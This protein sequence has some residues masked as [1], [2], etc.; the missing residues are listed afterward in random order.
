M[1]NEDKGTG[2]SPGDSNPTASTES[3]SKKNKKEKADVVVDKGPP[4]K[5]LPALQCKTTQLK[6]PGR[7]PGAPEWL[8]KLHGSRVTTPLVPGLSE[9]IAAD[10]I[11]KTLTVWDDRGVYWI[12]D[13]VQ[14]LRGC[15]EANVMRAAAGK[16][17]RLVPYRLTQKGLTSSQLFSLAMKLNGFIKL[18]T[19]L[20]KAEKASALYRLCRDEGHNDTQA[21]QTVADALG[22][23][24]P[25]QVHNYLVMNTAT[26]ALKRMVQS[27]EVSASVVMELAHLPQEE[28]EAALKAAV[29]NSPG[30]KKAT[31]AAAKNEVKI[32][33]NKIT[34]KT[35]VDAATVKKIIREHIE[36]D[37]AEIEPDHIRIMR[38]CMGQL[39]AED[40]RVKGFTGSVQFVT[41]PKSAK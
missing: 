21:Q 13:G 17:E 39:S 1:Q 18:D 9:S 41:S 25:A 29:A 38:F 15:E 22:D 23:I 19:A 14:R 10:G 31:A 5:D 3:T 35:C 34:A 24:S 28:Q 16:P 40:V 20:E 26:P 11:E 37:L 2:P 32:R 36:G 6:V 33:Q 30:G 12:L 8:V 27:G 7:D 4:G